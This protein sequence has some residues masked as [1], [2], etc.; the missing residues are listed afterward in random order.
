MIEVRLI[1]R[2]SIGSSIELKNHIIM[3]HRQKKK[4]WID[5][6]K[7]E[8]WR[9]DNGKNAKN[10]NDSNKTMH[11]IDNVNKT[12]GHDDWNKSNRKNMKCS[13]PKG[14][15][16]ETIWCR[17][18]CQHWPKRWLV[19]RLSRIVLF[20]HQVFLSSRMLPDT[21]RRSCRLCRK[22]IFFAFRWRSFLSFSFRRNTCSNRVRQTDS[23]LTPLFLH[24]FFAF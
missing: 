8:K 13:M 1:E 3:D 10:E 14:H 17:M 6:R 18:W 15:H 24:S 4:K 2:L 20:P 7:F 22:S 19:M 9:N 23:T 16:W 12:N 11:E 5:E 21:T